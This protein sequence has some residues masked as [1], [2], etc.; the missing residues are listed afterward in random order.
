MFGNND[1]RKEEI[2]NMNILTLTSTYPEPDDNGRV[3]T[4]TVKYFCEQWSK[5]G[6]R[7]IVIHSNSCFP[8]F[9][10]A[11]PQKIRMKLESKMGHTFPTKASRKPLVYEKDGI[12][13]Y[14]LP[15]T[16]CIPHGKFSDKRIKKQV[17]KIKTALEKDDF[18]PD[19]I[20]S[21]WVNPQVD[22]CIG[23]KEI[24]KVGTS[25]VFH[26]D[27]S[28][29]NIS[30]FDLLNKIK[31]FNAVGCR[32]ESYAD[33]VMKK[34]RL[35]TRPFI[36]Y[37][38]VPDSIA[39]KQ[40]EIVNNIDFPASLDFIYVGR[41]V[42]YKNVDTVI[43]ALNIKYRNDNYKLHIVGDGAE[44]ENLQNLAKKLGCE[45]KVIFYGQQPR[46]KV[47]EM[48]KQ[49]YAFIMVSNN[50]TFGM[51]YIEAMLA[52][53]ITIASKNGGVDGVIIDGENGYL[54]RQGDVEDLVK[55][56]D[57]IERNINIIS[58]RKKAIH[59]AYEYRDSKIAKRY[60]DDIIKW[61]DGDV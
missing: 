58:L 12:K 4:P 54:S 16:K 20:V 36:C 51:V 5:A 57:R 17:C 23:L 42:K 26:N 8:M 35:Q 21:H 50:E 25:L 55:T 31:L 14:R 43:K 38:G 34:L 2:L 39:E 6:N 60:L 24:Y 37:S 53:C 49:S 30:K 59:T 61:E 48:M 15:M 47:F 33:Y 3:V 46:D 11:I 56:L 9:F 52:G 1:V 44:K 10:Y 13:V 28:E 18:K 22:L 27:C 45:S 29:T 32:N 40:K 19:I 41:L 7:V